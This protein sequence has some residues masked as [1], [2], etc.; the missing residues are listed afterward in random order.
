LEEFRNGLKIPVG[1][2]D[3]DVAKV[4]CELRQFPPY[5]QA[6]AIPF[7]ELTRC[8]TVTKILE[9]RSTTDATGSVL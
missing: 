8:E 1:M 5:I 9:P 3:I 7:N 6:R 2:A 4:G